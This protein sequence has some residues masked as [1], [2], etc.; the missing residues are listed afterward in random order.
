[1]KEAEFHHLATLGLIGLGVLTLAS[2]LLVDAPY[3]RHSRPGWGPTLPNRW[4]WL[5]MESP[6]LCVFLPIYFLGSH[7]GRTVPLVL[8]GLWLTHYVHRTL[9]YPFQLDKNGKRVPLLIAFLGALFN[10][11]NAYLIARHLSELG[12]YRAGW[13]SDPRF[14]MGALLFAVGYYINRSSDLA[15][16]RL[17]KRGKPGYAI[18]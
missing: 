9:I 6:T 13:L 3:G 12:H 4:G 15:L 1:M 7:A 2:L 16:L 11:I 18:P 17:R 5:L 14:F 8:L 10:T